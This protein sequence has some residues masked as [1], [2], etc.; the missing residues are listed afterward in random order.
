MDEIKKWLEEGASDFNQGFA[1]FQR[2]SRNQS[3]IAYIARK[4]H[5]EMLKYEME[6]LS[7]KSELKEN[8]HS[9]P[10]V[11]S[12]Y[13]S[14]APENP[15]TVIVDERHINREDLS[16]ELQQVYDL[17]VEDYKS[18]RI[19]HEKMKLANSDSGRVEFREKIMKLNEKIKKRWAI[20]DSGKIPGKEDLGESKSIKINSARSYISK[21]LKKDTLTEEQREKVK[22]SFNVIITAGEVLKEETLAKLKEKGF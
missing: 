21:M 2:F 14:S 3:M 10:K 12:L 15:K 17:N 19:Y 20:I 16:P 1:L 9:L 5:L 13:N 8:P 6:K 11:S 18:L 7:S 4:Q 22:E